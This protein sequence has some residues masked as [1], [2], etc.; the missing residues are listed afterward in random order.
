MKKRYITGFL[1]LLAVEILIA[2]FVHDN[3]I[4]PYIGDVI[5]V[6]VV[7]CF[8]KIFLPKI[9]SY[10]TALGVMIF[11]FIVEFL[12]YIHIVDILGL[13]DI[14]FFRVLI[15]TSFSPV[16]LLCYAAGTAVTLLLIFITG[17]VHGK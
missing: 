14:K 3:F 11:A 5:V 13:G 17:K 9:N 15:G 12:Q 7:Y 1:L 6:W 16:D 4:R 2:L 8:V 10:L